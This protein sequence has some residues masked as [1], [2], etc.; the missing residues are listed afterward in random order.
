LFDCGLRRK[1]PEFS[2]NRRK[3]IKC[4]LNRNNFT[5]NFLWGKE[6]ECSKRDAGPE[7]MR[8]VKDCCKRMGGWKK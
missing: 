1:R 8:D 3:G 6:S 5:C 4:F 2:R 7:W